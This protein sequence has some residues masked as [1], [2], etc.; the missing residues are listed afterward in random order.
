MSGVEVELIVAELIVWVF[1]DGC[2]CEECVRGELEAYSKRIPPGG[3]LLLHDCAEEYRDYPAD[4]TYHGGLPREFRVIQEAERFL[5]ENPNFELVETT[6]AVPRSPGK[7]SGGT[8]AICR[9]E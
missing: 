7:F 3:Y 9:I 4:Q 5:E 1:L 6:P 2:H 8:W